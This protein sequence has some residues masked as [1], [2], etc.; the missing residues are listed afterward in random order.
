MAGYKET[1]RQNDRYDVP[2]TTALLALNVSKEV[3]MRL[4][5]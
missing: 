1:P 4:L 5:L 2:R 3:W